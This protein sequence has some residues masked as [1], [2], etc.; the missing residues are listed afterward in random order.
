MMNWKELVHHYFLHPL[1]K[2]FPLVFSL[3]LF[4]KQFG[5]SSPLR[6]TMMVSSSLPNLP[7]SSTL[8]NTQTSVSSSIPGSPLKSLNSKES[9]T[10]T[11]LVECLQEKLTKASIS[12]QTIMRQIGSEYQQQP[13][14]Q[15]QQQQ[16]SFLIT[17]VTILT[18]ILLLFS[19]YS[20]NDISYIVF[21]NISPR[22]SII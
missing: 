5:N 18:L 10:M 14:Q 21:N 20:N 6:G 7:T 9:M 22:Y 19:K 8:R 1:S 16:T 11:R 4:R 2:K 3:I 17:E 13:Q 12:F 15:Q